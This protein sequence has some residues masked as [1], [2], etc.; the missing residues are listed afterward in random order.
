MVTEFTLTSEF[1]NDCLILQPNGYLNNSGG[2][3]I[4]KEFSK[5]STKGINKV[6][7]DL[8]KSNV[9]NSIGI[10]FL[11]EIIDKLNDVDGKLFFTNTDPAIEK[12]FSIMGIY[13]FA[14][15]AATVEDAL[16]KMK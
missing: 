15:K 4:F 8:S 13:Q 1:K 2:E 9:I 6:I 16:E 7:I 11:I 5:H 14:Q 3:K 12:T 10:S